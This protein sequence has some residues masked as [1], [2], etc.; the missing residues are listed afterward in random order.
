MLTLALRAVRFQTE[1]DLSQNKIATLPEHLQLPA[2]KTVN[3]AENELAV[4][5]PVLFRWT[6]LA[7]IDVRRNRLTALAPA[8]QFG[9]LPRLTD[10]HV[11][12][13]PLDGSHVVVLSQLALPFEHRRF[14]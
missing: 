14:H 10:L 4:L 7:R 9:Q 1:L 11:D 6:S 3:L 5:P 12:D 2:L 8:A 13:N